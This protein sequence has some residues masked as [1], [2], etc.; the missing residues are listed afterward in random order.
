MFWRMDVLGKASKVVLAGVLSLTLLVERS[1]EESVLPLCY[2]PHSS[3]SEELEGMTREAFTNMRQWYHQ[4][5]VKTREKTDNCIDVRFSSAQDLA[6]QRYNGPE[7]ERFD[8]DSIEGV[9]LKESGTRIKEVIR[10]EERKYVDDIA[11]TQDSIRSPLS[12]VAVSTE[13]YNHIPFIHFLRGF[14][15]PRKGSQEANINPASIVSHQLGDKTYS[16]S[17]RS[18]LVQELSQTTVHEVGHA[19]G[20]S[21]PSR[22]VGDCADKNF[23][24]S[25]VPNFSSLEMTPLQ[26]KVLVDVGG[27]KSDFSTHFRGGGRMGY[28]FTQ[29]KLEEYD[30]KELYCGDKE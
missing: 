23:M 17:L 29:N 14:Y 1:Y 26:R 30:M 7:T 22:S 3:Y 4:N 16:D 18:R 8:P 6:P 2:T 15:A 19:S 9:L 24:N 21:H 5:G 20:F 10:D 12:G 25:S 11:A 13:N 28:W 27:R